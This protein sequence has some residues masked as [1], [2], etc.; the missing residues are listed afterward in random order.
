MNTGGRKTE[1]SGK[2]STRA[3]ISP[4]VARTDV[5]KQRSEKKMDSLN[6]PKGFGV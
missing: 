3:E 6:K 4:P 1:P 5:W 2:I